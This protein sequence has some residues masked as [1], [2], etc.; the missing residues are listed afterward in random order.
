[1][2]YLLEGPLLSKVPE[3]L[4]CNHLQSFCQTSNF[5]AKNQLDFRKKRNTELA[6]LTSTD[7]LLPALEEKQYDICAFLDYSVCFDTLSRSIL[8]D[9]LERYGIRGI[10]LDFIKAYFANRSQYVY[11][12]T[13]KSSIRCQELGVIQGSNTG[14]L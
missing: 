5:L 14:P 10:S 12:D 8:Y 11:Y 3:I 9:K 2:R 7:K 1:M 4:I 6:A 13:V